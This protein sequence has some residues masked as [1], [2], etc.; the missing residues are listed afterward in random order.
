M[1][2]GFTYMELASRDALASNAAL[3]ASASLLKMSRSTAQLLRRYR[4]RRYSLWT[5]CLCPMATVGC[6]K[7]RN[8]WGGVGSL[9]GGSQESTVGSP[10][11]ASRRGDDGESLADGRSA[12][13][14]TERVVREIA[15]RLVARAAAEQALLPRRQCGISGSRYQPQSTRGHFATEGVISDQY[16]FSSPRAPHR[17]HKNQQGHVVRRV[18]N[19][20]NCN[21]RK[22]FPVVRHRPLR[23][24]THVSMRS[25][26]VRCGGRC[27]A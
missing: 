10:Y 19:A 16:V 14:T 15:A 6:G 20:R 24:R 27:G 23:E 7:T 8:G 9:S 5:C 1:D 11:L 18:V 21:M 12:R 13:F 2:A 25:I 3:I 22:L 17:S 26:P 4:E